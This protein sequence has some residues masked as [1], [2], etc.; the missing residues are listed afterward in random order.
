[1]QFL[2]PKQQEFSSFDTRR[3]VMKLPT[4]LADTSTLDLG[5]LT[6]EQVAKL[7]DSVLAH[8][9]A[10]YRK[11]LSENCSLYSAFDSSI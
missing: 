6:P 3:D 9:L 4:R 2:Q 11:R 1:M 7:G 8:S 5:D 10:L